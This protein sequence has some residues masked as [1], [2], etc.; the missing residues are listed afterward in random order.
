[1]ID[2]IYSNT[3]QWFSN[4]NL[5]TSRENL[6]RWFTIYGVWLRFCELFV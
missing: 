1:M 2:S 6:S 5:T 4:C 3:N